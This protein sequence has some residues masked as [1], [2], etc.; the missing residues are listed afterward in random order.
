MTLV[1]GV[2]AAAGALTFALAL[3]PAAV[4]LWPRRFGRRR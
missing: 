3:E 4:L 1:T 2:E